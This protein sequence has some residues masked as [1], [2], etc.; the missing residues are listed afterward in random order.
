MSAMDITTLFYIT[1][2][3]SKK[4]VFFKSDTCYLRKILLKD[5]MSYSSLQSRVI[6]FLISKLSMH[7][8]TCTHVHTHFNGKPHYYV[9]SEERISSN[10]PEQKLKLEGKSSSKND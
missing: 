8:P 3:K 2:P 4:H 5:N 1:Y 10:N 7:E 9:E 6:D